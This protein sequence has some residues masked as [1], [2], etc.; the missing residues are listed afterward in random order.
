MDDMNVGILG[1]MTAMNDMANAYKALH[2]NLETIVDGLRYRDLLLIT[3][4]R[5]YPLVDPAD[6][7]RAVAQY[8]DANR[9]APQ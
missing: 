3:Y 9:E 5:S 4:A 8:Q 6:V 1:M 7:I 2:S